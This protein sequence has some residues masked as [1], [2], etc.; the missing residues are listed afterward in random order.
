MF[1]RNGVVPGIFRA[2]VDRHLAR[3]PGLKIRSRNANLPVAA[4]V[5]RGDVLDAIDGND[6][7]CARSQMGAGTGDGQIVLLFD[8]VDHV[9]AGNGVHAQTRQLSVDVDITLAGAGIT[10]PVGYRCG[11]G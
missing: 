10:V 3:R 4:G 11:E 2:D 9:I 6:N 1:C 5:N 8:G 7:L